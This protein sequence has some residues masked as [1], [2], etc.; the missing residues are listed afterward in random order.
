MLIHTNV[1]NPPL[2]TPDRQSL[3]PTM[4]E[5]KTHDNIC[6]YGRGLLGAYSRILTATEMG[7]RYLLVVCLR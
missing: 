1:S 5:K 2:T 6:S 7:E 3:H 4:K